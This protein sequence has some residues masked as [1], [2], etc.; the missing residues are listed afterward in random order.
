MNRERRKQLT[1]ISEDIDAIRDN[2]ENILADEEDYHD[3]IPE[4]LQY[5]QRAGDSEN[6]IELMNDAIECM[7]E[8]IEIIESIF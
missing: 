8:A 2:L 6:A 1:K 7:N 5:S 3:N 4:N